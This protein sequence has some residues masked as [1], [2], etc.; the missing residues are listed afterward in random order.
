MEKMPETEFF[1]SKLGF[2]S[3]DSTL[4]NRFVPLYYLVTMKCQQNLIIQSCQN[5]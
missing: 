1:S 5:C 4:V 3:G 2:F